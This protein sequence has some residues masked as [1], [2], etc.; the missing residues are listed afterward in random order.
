MRE[1]HPARRHW[2]VTYVT[3][4]ERDKGV[5]P[6]SDNAATGRAAAQQTETAKAQ[7]TETA[8]AQ[9]TETA[10]AQ[11]TEPAKPQQTEPTKAQQTEPTKAQQ[12]EP[13]EAQQTEPAEAQRTDGQSRLFSARPRAQPEKEVRELKTTPQE[14]ELCGRAITA[15]PDDDVTCTQSAITCTQPIILWGFPVYMREARPAPRA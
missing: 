1:A 9:R 2:K 10:K 14:A 3:F 13:A 12:T 6:G 15:D 7:R 8:K 11:Q 5:W 4:T